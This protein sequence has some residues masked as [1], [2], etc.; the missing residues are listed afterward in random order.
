MK[1]RLAVFLLSGAV[2]FGQQNTIQIPDGRLAFGAFVAQFGPD[3]T[4]TLD[5]EGWPPF[6]GTWKSDGAQI[7]LLVP[8]AREGC[9]GPGRYRISR[10]GHARHLRRRIRWVHGATHD[11]RSQHVAARRR[12]EESGRAADRAHCRRAYALAARGRS[13]R[14]AIGRRFEGLRRPAF[15]KAST[16]PTPGTS[17]PERTSG[18]AGRLPA[19]RI[20]VRSCGAI[21]SS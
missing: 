17:R 3:G 11:S 18:G 10:R 16:S 5:G 21:G 13:P 2:L 1:V 4:F 14:P 8:Q 12:T 15:P 20:P 9:T 19:S 7:E 6:K